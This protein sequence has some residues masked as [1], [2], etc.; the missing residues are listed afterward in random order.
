MSAAPAK[1]ET[2]D[3]LVSA[4]LNDDGE[5][6][7]SYLT[8]P[9]ADRA[10]LPFRLVINRG[11]KQGVRMGHKFLVYTPGEEVRDPASN[12]SLGH[13]EI[14]RGRGEVVHV[15]ENMSIIRSLERSHLVP[16]GSIQVAGFEPRTREME[17]P[18]RTPKIGDLAR[19]LSR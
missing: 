9:Q 3:A 15:M 17:I 14:L 1:N 4:V 11:E 19:P 8:N 13:L 7:D 5:T 18:F 2:K 12:K 10:R 6:L 16:Q